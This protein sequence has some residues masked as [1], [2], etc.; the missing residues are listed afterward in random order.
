[1]ALEQTWRWFG[2]QDPVSLADVRQAGA[3]GIVSAL[4]HIPNGQVW[5]VAE[6]Q[7]RKDEIEQAGLVWSV[8][9]SVPIHEDIKKASG[10]YKQYIE[11]YKECLVNL[12]QCGIDTVCYNFMPVLDWTRTDLDYQLP[13]GSRALRFDM[14]EFCAFE[15]YILKR[16]GAEKSYTAQQLT[17]AK[18]WL[19]GADEGAVQKLTRNI[20]AGLPGSEES[21][22]LEAFADVLTTYDKV[23]EAALR[24]NLYSFLKEITPVAEDA[25]VLLAIHPDDPP[26]PILGLPRVVS[27][28]S[29]AEQLLAAYES[30]HNGLCFCTGSYGVRSDN[31]LPGMAERLGNRINFVH[32]RATQRDADGNFHEADH[33]AGDVDMYGVMKALLVEQKRREAEGRQD[34]R[35]PF[36]PD[37]GHRM[38][39]DLNPTKRTNPGYTAIGRLRGLAELRGL[40][41]G[42]ERGL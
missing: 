14:T 9:E 5:T 40:E 19:D 6:I 31:D 27:T 24:T 10:N 29:D 26:F 16:P 21:F 4:H 15:V 30:K 39:D 42:I 13:D 8:V 34:L 20:I 32:L 23:D 22:T 36:R 17:R 37:H 7:K 35:M 38:L 2:P 33:L 28:E 3:T 12:A 11:T 25:G 41:M 18:A 1:M